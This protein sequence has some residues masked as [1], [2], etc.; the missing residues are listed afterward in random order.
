MY[1]QTTNERVNLQ[2][3]CLGQKKGAQN[4]MVVTAR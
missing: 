1:H 2:P 4:Y 3:G